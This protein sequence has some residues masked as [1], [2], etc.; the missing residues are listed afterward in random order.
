MTKDDEG[1]K[2]FDYND[3]I[4]EIVY[5]LHC[6][7]GFI[8]IHRAYSLPFSFSNNAVIQNLIFGIFIFVFIRP[9]F[10]T[11]EIFSNYVWGV[12]S[13][14]TNVRFSHVI[15]L[16]KT[17]NYLATYLCNLKKIIH[18]IIYIK[19]GRGW[20]C[21]FDKKT[22]VHISSSI[23]TKISRILEYVVFKYSPII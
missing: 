15:S 11:L 5:L 16:F 8:L 4:R 23:D 1:K 17:V 3:Y 22:F 19:K 13:G 21:S 10:K 18:R 2:S 14:D 6:T 9:Y 12:S 20:G 7:S